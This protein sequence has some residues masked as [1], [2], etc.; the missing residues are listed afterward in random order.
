[1]NGLRGGCVVAMLLA[2][3]APLW[4]LSGSA[5]S[6]VGSLETITPVTGIAS[7]PADAV[8]GPTAIPYAGASDA[9][10]LA[11]VELWARADAEAWGFTSLV[12]VG[13]EGTFTFDPGA[14]GLFHFDLVAEDV[15][16]NRSVAPFGGADVGDGSTLFIPATTEWTLF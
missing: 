12:Q 13:G 1:M 7:P 10:G 4:A 5:Q 2:V 16:G 11:R 15:L 9:S 8:A 6:A 3:G 14:A